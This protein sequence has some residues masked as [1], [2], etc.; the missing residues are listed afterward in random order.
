MSSRVALSLLVLILLGRL[1]TIGV[2]PLFDKTE[3]R[4]GEIGREMAE[5]GNWVTPTLHG[6]DPFWGK[7]PLHFWATA[8]SFRLFSVNEWAARLP[9]F[10]SGIGI[11]IITYVAGLILFRRREEALPAVWVLASSVL[12]F[13]LSGQVLLDGTFTLTLTGALAA[14]AAFVVGGKG[15][16]PGYLFFLS[17]GLAMLAKGPIGIVL[18]GVVLALHA[19]WC[20]TVSYI[21]ALPWIGGLPLLLAVASPWYLLAEQRTPGFL[22]YFFV[23]EHLLRY[24]RSDYGDLYGHGHVAPYG[25][26]WLLAMAALLP[27]TPLIIARGWRA[28]RRR[29][30][31]PLSEAERYLWVWALATPLFFTLSR[32]L[33]FPYIFP[34]LPPLALLVGLSLH[35]GHSGTRLIAGSTLFTLLL[36]LGG[37][38]YGTFVFHPSPGDILFLFVP[39]LLLLVLLAL[40]WGKGRVERMLPATVLTVPL[41]VTALTLFWG[42]EI[43]LRKSTRHLARSE[44]VTAA[45]EGRELLFFDGL[46]LSAEFYFRCEANDLK[47][48]GAALL[49]KAADKGEQILFVR[50]SREKYLPVFGEESLESLGES[51][52]YRIYLVPPG[53]GVSGE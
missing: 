18:V 5:S 42:D 4:Y 40:S 49:E 35:R 15:K 43:G 21:A 13:L 20:R 17:L 44:V 37:A 1:A 23:N 9:G 8:I 27:W 31:E 11:L 53:A 39:L 29:R 36:L 50:K 19:L 41:A 30:E 46:P 52:K 6:G 7:P 32:S 24:T 16:L 28:V 38:L 14:F 22:R 47:G 25:M 26:I 33:S 12:F 48:D 10:L 2:P 3:G 34:S 45:R 51:G